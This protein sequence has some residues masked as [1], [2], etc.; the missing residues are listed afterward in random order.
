MAMVGGRNVHA[1]PF[2]QLASFSGIVKGNKKALAD[3]FERSGTPYTEEQFAERLEKAEHWIQAYA[4]EEDMRLAPAKRTDYFEALP[5]H[6]RHWITA[7]T[8]WI[9]AHEI[10]LESANERLY[11]IPQE[12]ESNGNPKENQKAFFLDI[13]QL[14]FS[15]QSGPRL[16]T[17]LAAVPNEDYV[18]LIRF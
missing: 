13:Y 17:F 15:R 11:G 16:A 12:G 6:R 2:R 3:I 14:L 1:V 5:P 4:P 18:G 7:L 8:E 9:N 10:T